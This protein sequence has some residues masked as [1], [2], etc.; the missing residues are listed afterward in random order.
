MDFDA[1]PRVSRDGSVEIPVHKM[2]QATAEMKYQ[3]IVMLDMVIRREDLSSKKRKQVC[4]QV[5]H[6]IFYDH[7]YTG[8]YGLSNWRAWNSRVD[9]ANK[10]GNTA[11]P[12]RGQHKGS[13]SI[14]SRIEE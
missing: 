3:I 8:V 4:D 11:H 14:A 10:T 6:I 5:S 13:K 2:K 1:S 7:G 9:V 12:L